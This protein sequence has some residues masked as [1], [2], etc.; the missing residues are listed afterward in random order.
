MPTFTVEK[1]CE[2]KK[3]REIR[4]VKKKKESSLKTLSCEKVEEKSYRHVRMV[5]L[6]LTITH[7]NARKSSLK[8]ALEVNGISSIVYKLFVFCNLYKFY[9]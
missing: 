8:V 5:K 7:L 1:W 6:R 3:K 2:K 4:N 9:E